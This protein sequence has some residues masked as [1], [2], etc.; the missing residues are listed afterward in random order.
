[1]DEEAQDAASR[2]R[3]RGGPDDSQ[4]DDEIEEE[5]LAG[6][7]AGETDGGE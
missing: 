2:T 7:A 5:M 4:I 3:C 1:M 6:D